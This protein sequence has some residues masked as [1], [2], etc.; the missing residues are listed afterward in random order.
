MRSGT[1]K[2]GWDL[3]RM[4][5][6]SFNEIGMKVKDGGQCREVYICQ[7]SM[8][9]A[10]NLRSYHIITSSLPCENCYLGW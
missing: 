8:A 7:G 3:L 5:N 10:K 4:R 9:R 1:Q 6:T 2:E